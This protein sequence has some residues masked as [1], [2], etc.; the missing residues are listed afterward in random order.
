MRNRLWLFI[1]LLLRFSNVQCQVFEITGKVIDGFTREPVAY[2]FITAINDTAFTFADGEGL[3]RILV[4]TRVS[5]LNATA[6]GYI[7]ASISI[8]QIKGFYIQF[9][10][11]S[12]AGVMQQEANGSKHEIIEKFISRIFQNRE[13]NNPLLQDY[14]S[15][16]LY[17]KLQFELN[18]V[19]DELK[20]NKVLKPFEGLLDLADTVG[21]NQKPSLPFFF[22]EAVSQVYHRSNPIQQRQTVEGSRSVGAENLTL[23]Q[24]LKDIYKNVS[25]Y[26]NYINLF[27]KSFVSPLSEE[28]MKYYSYSISDSTYI[29]G[30]K[31]YRVDFYSNNRFERTFNGNFW[32]HDTTFALQ[33]IMLTLPGTPYLNFVEDLAY[34]K[35][36]TCSKDNLWV[37]SHEQLIVKFSR[38][39]EGMSVTIRKSRYFSHQAIDDPVSKRIFK[40]KSYVTISPEAFDRSKSFWEENRPESLTQRER[41]IFELVDTLKTIPAF[42]AYVAAVVVLFTGRVEYKKTDLGP[43]YHLLSS[44]DVEGIRTRVGIR[45]ND[46]F[47]TRWRFEGYGA[48]GFRDKQLKYMGGIRYTIRKK[49]FVAAGSEYRHDLVQ[50]GLHE[51]IFKDEGFLVILFRRNPSDKL[52][53]M[54]G[55]KFYLESAFRNGLWLKAQYQ[56]NYYKPRSIFFSHFNPSDEKIYEQ[57]LRISEASLL[58]RYS[59]QEKFI[60]KKFKRT[61]LGTDFPVFQLSLT[62]GFSGFLEGEFNYI[63]IGWRMT[64]RLNTF[65]YGFL[66]YSFE[67]GWSD[68]TVP[69]PMLFIH[70]GNESHLFD[71]TAFNLMSH[72]E[73]YTDRYVSATAVHHL[74]GYLWRRLPLLRV[75]KWREL[76]SARILWGHLDS[77]NRNLVIPPS[78]VSAISSLPYIEA[79]TG[80]ENVLRIFRVDFLWRITYRD[81]PAVQQNGI[82]L[83]AQLIF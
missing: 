67:A 81:R 38:K 19:T 51:P 54:D 71:Y 33:R 44:N 46:N 22:T 39:V 74:D 79:G 10:L 30:K 80:L 36:Y 2:A 56:N 5:S 27:G 45:T 37:P 65:P 66:D 3:F 25:I 20:K 17:E 18:D 28:G 61:S 42:Q 40:Q 13:K 31:C 29:E 58:I 48:Y 14:F 11:T 1:I 83:S 62:R 55:A 73:F 77:K 8:H 59:Y 43:Y 26:D 52:A 6:K 7:P 75:L 63:R 23:M 76:F 78:P 4:S 82:R 53:L 50:P 34:V 68:G 57:N 15:Y 64:H 70:R 60:E 49:P 12:S 41:R 69:Y 21:S 24:I 72:Y 35:V 16:R 9:E 47:S 32:F